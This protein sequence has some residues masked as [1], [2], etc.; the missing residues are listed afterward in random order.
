MTSQSRPY[1]NNLGESE[2]TQFNQEWR[3]HKPK[4]CDEEPMFDNGP[5]KHQNDVKAPSKLQSFVYPGKS[6]KSDYRTSQRPPIKDSLLKS[7][8]NGHHSSTSLN[9]T[10]DKCP[11]Y[12]YGNVYKSEENESTGSSG[13]VNSLVNDNNHYNFGAFTS[14]I[15]GNG[16]RF[17]THSDFDK[18]SMI[19]ERSDDFLSDYMLQPWMD[20]ITGGTF[21]RDYLDKNL[22]RVRWII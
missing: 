18:S 8:R 15:Y 1:G 7:V 3:Q 20:K 17:Q 4:M 5:E 13:N 14:V 21:R 11:R 10:I 22:F 16:D 6:R 12:G 19:S 2:N 9:E